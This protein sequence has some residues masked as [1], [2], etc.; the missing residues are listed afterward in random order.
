MDAEG[1]R[2]THP[3]VR[4]AVYHSA[5][6]ATKRTA[7][8]ALV[9]AYSDRTA[10]GVAERRAFHLAAATALPD[11]EVASEL[12]E[13]ARA[14]SARHSHTM[15]AA[16]FERAVRLTPPGE[17]R[18]RRILD[19]AMAGQ[20]AGTLDVVGP[21]LDL[22]IAETDN[23]DLRTAAR[24]LQCRIQM[25]SGRPAQARDQLLDLAEQ[26]EPAYPF[27]SALMC[28]QAAVVSIALGEQRV[29]AGMVRRAADLV[30]ALDDGVA[31]PVLVA[32]AVTLAVNGDVG[33]AREILRRCEPHLGGYDPLSIDQLLV[34]T[35]LA[36]F[37][38]DETVRARHWLETAV[39]TTR[40]AQAVGLLPFQLSWLSLLYWSDGDW[41][42]A[43]AQ[44]HDADAIA[45]ETG[46]STERPNS[47][48]ALATIEAA[49]GQ[50]EDCHRHAELAVQLGAQ[51]SN[52]RIYEA[53]AA[54][55]L[56]LLELGAGHPEAAAELLGAAGGYAIAHGF[57]DP[58][59][60]SWA[61]NLCEALAR[62]GRTDAAQRAHEAVAREAA[63]TGRPTE[64]AT[65]A[66]CRGLLMADDL[67][68]GARAFEEALRW[69]DEARRPFERARTELCYGEF[70][71]RHQRRVDARGVLGNALATFRRLGASAWARRA[72]AELQATGV[73]SRRRTPRPVERLTPQELQVALVVADG[74]TNSEAA[75]RLFLSTK[76]VEFHLSNAY[77]KLGIRS[78][79]ELAR[80]VLAALPGQPPQNAPGAP[81]ASV[82]H[83]PSP[84][85]ELGRTWPGRRA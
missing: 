78:R 84:L 5:S 26:T 18:T 10:P 83:A 22:A 66:R 58:A 41:V 21:L 50:E 73:R 70:L 35:G 1:M 51:Q 9:A 11:E 81:A 60:F 32:Q 30:A 24:H 68:G 75:T 13:A 34:L 36:Y 38:L 25:W 23:D 67:D 56:G 77:R 15:A 53:Q 49:L 59:L 31:L 4:S 19:A 3:L 80:K 28:S 48:I 55:V 72:E 8:R 63:Q 6:P 45:E 43:L 52:A 61:G 14:A 62:S 33:P 74:A 57:G 40:N 20:A 46:W 76:T 65:E 37:S 69:H 17:T 54:R 42:S 64:H 39:Q 85:V 47:L 7:H 29:A 2:F 16:L 71:R 12:A 44:A 82:P 27:W 79:V